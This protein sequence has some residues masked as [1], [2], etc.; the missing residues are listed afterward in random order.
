MA[1]WATFQT[2]PKVAEIA[3]RK[4]CWSLT[5]IIN[6]SFNISQTAEHVLDSVSALMMIIKI[7][8]EMCWVLLSTWGSENHL[9]IINFSCWEDFCEMFLIW[10]MPHI[11]KAEGKVIIP[12]IIWL[13]GKR[14]KLPN[15]WD[16]RNSTVNF[17]FQKY[18]WNRYV[19]EIDTIKRMNTWM[20]LSLFRK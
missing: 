7:S 16:V 11:R 13:Q 14:K 19:F 3:R 4:M 10:R 12:R 8:K 6:S 15:F 1:C 20:F 17:S 2:L 5:R 9:S 18:L